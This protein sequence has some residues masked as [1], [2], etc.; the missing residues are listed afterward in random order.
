MQLKSVITG[1]I[2]KSRDIEDKNLL[3]TTLQNLFNEISEQ[4]S[5]IESFE[6]Y[7]GDSFQ[8][9]LD[10]PKYALRIALLIR[11]G[12]RKKS[13]TKKLWDARIG[14]GIGAINYLKKNIK[15]SNGKA[16]EFSGLS[17]DSI[18]E[19][20]HKRIQIS[21][22]DL[23]LN[24]QLEVF[25]ELSDAIIKRWSK[26]SAEVIYRQLLYKE[27]QKNS[28]KQLGIS[29]SAVQQRMTA[30]DF[31]AINAYIRY[32]ELKISNYKL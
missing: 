10:D 3:I 1:D 2:I 29:Q 22:S 18:K 16:F 13:F 15:I 20:H 19:S 30:A 25:N 24:K 27:T 7:R 23:Q 28:A 12:L 32:F 21:T 17:L 6:I 5:F 31:N 14:I 11:L 8:A 26:K 4:F 9:L